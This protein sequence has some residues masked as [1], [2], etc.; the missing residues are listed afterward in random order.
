MVRGYWISI[1]ATLS[2]LVHYLFSSLAKSIL[3]RLGIRRRNRSAEDRPGGRLDC[4]I[5]LGE[6]Q[7]AR[8]S[9]WGTTS[10][11]SRHQDA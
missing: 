10:S 1:L 8:S 6:V 2:L 7:I 9:R 5:G 3:L 11:P 4:G